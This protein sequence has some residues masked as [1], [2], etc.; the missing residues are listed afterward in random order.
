VRGWGL[1]ASIAMGLVGACGTPWVDESAGDIEHLSADEKSGGSG[2]LKVRVPVDSDHAAFLLTA[3]TET[4]F[5]SVVL[6]VETPDG[7]EVFDLDDEV[8]SGRLKTG[9]RYATDVVS[10]NWPILE[11]DVPLTE[12]DWLVLFGVVDSESKYQGGVDVG[13][14]VLLGGDDVFDDGV[15][16][17]RVVLAGTMRSDAEVQRALGVAEQWWADMYAQVGIDLVFLEGTS[18]HADLEQPGFGSDAAYEE[19]SGETETGDVTVVITD[20]VS[21]SPDIYGVAGGIPGP[22]VASSRSVVTVAALTHAGGDL[23]FSLLEERILGETLAHEVGHYLGL[24]HPVETDWDKWDAIDDTP[25][26]DDQNS[27]VAQ[28]GTNLMFPFPICGATTCQAQNGI[29]PLQGASMNRYTG[30]R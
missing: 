20:S 25:E 8:A 16:T 7:D 24:F 11:E 30:V 2:R 1:A 12:G 17:V 21:G 3:Q 5:R 27:C 13:L 22:L 6:S 26:C 28:L 19:I 14:D 23:Q 18:S 29:T 4:G 10:L 15:L 9:A